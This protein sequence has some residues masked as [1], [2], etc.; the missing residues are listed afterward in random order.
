MANK[1]VI[2]FAG[3][4]NI[5]KIN[6]QSFD[7]TTYSI[8][9]QLVAIQIFEDLFSPFMSGILTIKDSLDFMNGLPMVGQELLDISIFTPTLKDK[10][11]HIKGQFYINEI[12]NRE[13]A[14]ERS[15]I[16]E[17][18]FVSKEAVLDSNVKLSK[19]F[20]GLISDVVKN[21]LTDKLVRFD[22]AKNINI[23]S[24]INSTQYVSNFWSPTR[25]MQYLCEQAL[26]KNESASYIFFENKDGFNFGS[27][28]TLS[29]SPTITQE[30][31]YNN[32]TQAVSPT[33]TSQRDIQSDYQRITM[34]SLKKGF[35]VLKRSSEGMLT[36]VAFSADI[37]TQ[38]YH[39][40]I[41]NYGDWF[42]GVNQLNDFPLYLKEDKEFP[43]F[44]TARVLE[45]ARSHDNFT[46][47]GD[48]SNF[49]MS[50]RRIS[51]VVQATDYVVEINVPG[52]TDYTVGQVV[53]LT[54][55]QTEPMTK[56]EGDREQLDK[57]FSGRYLVSSINHYITRE[58]HE[59]SMELV[60]DS[61]ISNFSKTSAK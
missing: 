11:G 6:I 50:Q 57:I 44:Y 25:N 7:G 59:C 46:D 1:D 34:F 18:S 8:S 52:R 36:S 47:K 29:T 48:T 23:E 26:N 5:E 35:N 16:Y 58:K 15:V 22:T 19:G 41:F 56:T 42:S 21:V 61:Y 3:D 51:E 32:S 37:T 60:K 17:L 38:R 31:R 55:F 24:T 45:E 14:Q 43:I 9:N 53:R 54:M 40:S 28:E 49:K 20:S 2:H 27:I 39:S 30:F 13:Y 10:G 12:K 4:I 33:G